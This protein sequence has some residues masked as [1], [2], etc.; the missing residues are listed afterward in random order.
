MFVVVHAW[1]PVAHAQPAEAPA[2]LRAVQVEVD[3]STGQT[4]A[5]QLVGKRGDNWRLRTDEGDVALSPQN[6]IRVTLADPPEA[7]LEF[8]QRRRLPVLAEAAA[9][10]WLARAD[11]VQPSDPQ[12]DAHLDSSKPP[13]VE[14]WQYDALR[15]GR[16]ADPPGSAE[17]RQALLTLLAESRGAPPAWLIAD[18][19]EQ[20]ASDR[21][22]RRRGPAPA[23]PIERRYP[24]ATP[25]EIAAAMQKTQ[26]VAD[27][28]QA[29]EP[30]M[31]KIETDHF[32]IY[33]A[34]PKSVDALLVKASDHLYDRFAD[35]FNLADGE[36]LWIAK[37][38]I[39][40]TSG[41]APFIALSQQAFGIPPG[42]SGQAAGYHIAVGPF[43]CVVL[44]EV[45]MPWFRTPEETKRWLVEL[46]IHETS[47]AFLS[48]FISP[49]RLPSWLDEGVAELNAKELMD[50]PRQ[51][52]SERRRLRAHD[53]I[54]R[55]GPTWFRPLFDMRAIIGGRGETYGAAH[56]VV[57]FLYRSDRKRFVSMV[58]AIKQGQSGA[59]AL[60]T[61][62]GM[63]YNELNAR[64]AEAAR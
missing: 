31:R 6:L 24:I 17:S 53:E 43:R 4:F 14:L 9:F 55:N 45:A 21:R 29:L 58:E 25:E 20:D 15:Q 52:V 59:E 32:L 28:M 54:R 56:S 62:F 33:T 60:Q 18:A 26:E 35:L 30:G 44:G 49:A 1:G 39:Y 11:V 37:L 7:V 48:R 36:N 19:A 2:P 46:L 63:S 42:Q 41:E 57:E 40:A 34:L 16:Q 13:A 27:L 50:K 3:L 8:A 23:D 38:P 61:H 10:A 51:T 5:G 64:W 22:T 47:H 12:S